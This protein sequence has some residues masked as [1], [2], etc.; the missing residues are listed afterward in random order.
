[1]A[2]LG[3]KVAGKAKEVQGAVSGD[4][5]RANEGRMQQT[6]GNLEDA[7]QGVKDTAQGAARQ[8]AG[9]ASG[10]EGEEL[11]GRAQRTKGDIER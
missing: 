8:V 5:S 10:D 3:D 1:M 2:G 7:A 11:H 4:E 6:K 9:S